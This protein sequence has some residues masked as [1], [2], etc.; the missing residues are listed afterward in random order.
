MIMD[1]IEV[2]DHHQRLVKVLLDRRLQHGMLAGPETTAAVGVARMRGNDAQS[3]DAR[4]VGRRD[5]LLE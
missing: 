3:V 1:R 2:A 4:S 5:V